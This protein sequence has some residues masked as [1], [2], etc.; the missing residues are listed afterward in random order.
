MLKLNNNKGIALFITL[1]FCLL[2]ILMIAGVLLKA[3]NN[4]TMV[5][6][7]IKRMKAISLA[8]AGIAYAY[9]YL[10][11]VGPNLPTPIYPAQGTIFNKAVRLSYEDRCKL[12]DGKLQPYVQGD[13]P[14]GIL[15]SIVSKVD[16]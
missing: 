9:W 11:A 10:S 15:D 6:N 12:V 16:Y 3:I 2:L 4:A 8:E 5:E 7:N 13:I 1:L 14:D